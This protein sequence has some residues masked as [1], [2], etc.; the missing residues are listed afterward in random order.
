MKFLLWALVAVVVVM[1]LT[2]SKKISSS[3]SPNTTEPS[4]APEPGSTVE[5]MVQCAHC[6]THIPASESIMAPSGAVFCSDEHRL[7]HAKS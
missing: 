7:R 3:A 4:A 2:R 1:W 5:R 6:G